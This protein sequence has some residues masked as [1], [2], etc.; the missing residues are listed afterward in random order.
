MPTASKIYYNVAGHR[1]PVAAGTLLTHLATPAA[2]AQSQSRV[3]GAGRCEA[4]LGTTS[5][6]RRPSQTAAS[7]AS[8][9]SVASIHS[10]PE[11]ALHGKFPLHAK[12]LNPEVQSNGPPHPRA[13]A[14]AVARTPYITKRKVP[15]YAPKPSGDSRYLR[16]LDLDLDRNAMGRPRDLES[17]LSRDI[18]VDVSTVQATD[19]PTLRVSHRTESSAS[20]G[21]D[22]RSALTNRRDAIAAQAE[23]LKHSDPLRFAHF[24]H[25]GES[26]EES[27]S[28]SVSSSRPCSRTDST[29]R[30]LSDASTS[31]STPN[32]SFVM[33]PPQPPDQSEAYEGDG[34]PMDV[35]LQRLLD[36]EPSRASTTYTKANSTTSLTTRPTT[37]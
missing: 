28:S 8:I 20:G 30:E 31:P 25:S 10:E 5:I 27:L 24:Q 21:S 34:T 4:Q 16:D 18:G 35:A 26:G 11:R 3:P 22:I 33:D 12:H 32:E 37:R 14:V 2:L 9:H 17:H 1:V 15:A 29:T 36:E 13:R 6:K 19:L 7:A 23:D